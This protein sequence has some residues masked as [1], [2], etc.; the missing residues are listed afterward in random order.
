MAVGPTGTVYVADSGNNRIETFSSNGAFQGTF[1]SFGS[2]TDQFNYPYGVAVGPTGTVYVAD[3]DNNRIETFSSNGA[4]Q[5]TFGSFGSGNNQF[6]FPYGVAVGPTGTVYVADSGNN[7]IETFSS[8][9]AFQGTFGSS[10]SGNDQFYFPYGVAVG[11]TG[12][13]YVADT[14]NDRIERFFDPASW[15]SGTATFTDPTVGPTS[16][17]LGVSG[18]SLTINSSMGLVVGS[19]T[20]VNAGSVVE[21]SGGSITTSA[22]TVDGTFTYGGGSHSLGTITVA[23]GGNFASGSVPFT[24]NSNE[25]LDLSGSFGSAPLSVAAGGFM[26]MFS[27]SSLSSPLSISGGFNYLGGTITSSS[28]T[29]QPGGSMLMQGSTPISSP[30][31][32]VEGTYTMNN[33]TLSSAVVNVGGLFNY[34]NG[35]FNPGTVV[36]QAGG[37]LYSAGNTA[38]LSN[39]NLIQILPGGLIS[40]DGS[41]AGMINNTTG[42]ITGAGTVSVTNFTNYGTI[43]PIGGVLTFSNPAGSSFTN[44]GTIIIPAG[45]E[46][47]FESFPTNNGTIS[48]AGGTFSTNGQTLA[49]A[50][51]I[52][53]FGILETGGLTNSATLALSG[54]SSVYGSVTNSSSATIHLSGNS[55]NVFYGAVANS[56]TL[57]ID[58]GA[59]GTIYGAYSGSGKIIDNGSLY[60]NASSVSGPI[61][62]SGNLTIGSTSSGPLVQIASGSGVSTLAS[63]TIV[64]GSTLDLT[65]NSLIVHNGN[66]SALVGEIQQGYNGGTWSGEGITSSTAAGTRNTALGIELNNNGSGGTLISTFEGQPVT[67]SDVLI[68]YTYFGDAN[69]DGVVNG[70]DYTLID[71]G[72]NNTLTGWRNGDFNYDG[73]VNGDDYTL[74]DN[75]F[76]TQGV[77]V[78]GM[79]AEIIASDTAQ[80]EDSGASSTAVPEPT[81]L[82]MITLCIAALVKRHR[83]V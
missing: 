35:N 49:N 54:Q 20:T 42:Q 43:E 68:K 56:G 67:S 3:T 28:I 46:G 34:S 10:G 41:G 26:V 51:Q 60:L 23:S 44:G 14:N 22:L 38:L 36:I 47:L 55:P 7:R 59:S 81:S 6:Y 79:P 16:I 62:G 64:S 1:G 30:V 25:T 33:G 39:S 77:S 40:L 75:A 32:N 63:L 12:T 69:L 74:I 76:N 57:T 15:T 70:S 13:V 19:T 65:N 5:G 4:F 80:I 2:G 29:V 45:A 52:T 11:P 78:A 71:N 21:L 9:G 83:R 61:S 8:N 73:V 37:E 66:L 50:S 48:M 82:S 17:S 31:L 24:L 58:A 72:F 53:G 27:G 18:G